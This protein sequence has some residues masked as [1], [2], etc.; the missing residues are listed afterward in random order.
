MFQK[1]QDNIRNNLKDCYIEKLEESDDIEEE[2]L[3]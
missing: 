3:I 2:F 1:M